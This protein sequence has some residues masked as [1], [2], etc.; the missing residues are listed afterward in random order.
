MSQETR[1]PPEV[2]SQYVKD[3][4]NPELAPMVELTLVDCF[5]I[6][7]RLTNLVHGAVLYLRDTGQRNTA[8]ELARRTSDI[9]T[10]YDP[11]LAE[12]LQHRWGLSDPE[13]LPND[14]AAPG[15][16]MPTRR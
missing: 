3:T 15:S 4:V 1:R 2:L 13:G 6:I 16:Q 12:I 5:R 11:E 8:S 9:L 10:D 7:N 14:P